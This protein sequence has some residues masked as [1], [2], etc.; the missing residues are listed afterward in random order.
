MSE[1]QG[2]RR[3]LSVLLIGVIFG[4]VTGFLY[5]RG[6]PLA[7]P[8]PHYNRRCCQH[9]RILLLSRSSSLFSSPTN[10]SNNLITIASQKLPWE[11]MDETHQKPILNLSARDESPENLLDVTVN[12]QQQGSSSDRSTVGCSALEWDKGQRWTVTK[13]NLARLGLDVVSNESRILDR[14]PQLLR[15]DSTTVSETAEWVIAEF[16]ADY[17]ESEWQL[18]SFT[19]EDASYGLEFLCTMTM[20]TTTEATKELCRQSS[21]LLLQGIQGGIQERAIQKALGA[22]S[23]ATSKA[24]QSIISDSVTSF[25]QLRGK[26]RNKI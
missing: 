26:N 2:L 22:A 9:N 1:D 6:R 23:D 14:C 10:F 11:V 3:I 19:V 7:S 15:L 17:L 18:L 8:Q 4:Q 13:Q 25:R 5:P 16:D 21:Q 24:T 12:S 20:M